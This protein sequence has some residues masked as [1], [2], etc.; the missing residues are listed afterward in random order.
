MSGIIGK[1]STVSGTLGYTGM[2]VVQ[3]VSK[4][5]TTQYTTTGGWNDTSITMEITPKLARSHIHL[6]GILQVA[7]TNN[8]LAGG[9]SFKWKRSQSGQTD[10]YPDNL[11]PWDGSGAETYLDHWNQASWTAAEFNWK[12]PISGLDTTVHSAGSEVTYTL[13]SITYSL[14]GFVIGNAYESDSFFQATEIAI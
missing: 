13:Y 4:R 3:I 10:V 8:S 12:Q 5:S 7:M 9:C 11:I 6:T 14:D 2:G 1:G